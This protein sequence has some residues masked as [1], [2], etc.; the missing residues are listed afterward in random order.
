MCALTRRIIMIRKATLVAIGLATCSSIFTA[1]ASRVKNS[2]LTLDIATINSDYT[3]TKNSSNVST[4]LLVPFSGNSRQINFINAQISYFDKLYQTYG[5]GIGHRKAIDD[6]VYGI[7]GVYDYQISLNDNVFKRANVGLELLTKE[8]SIRTNFYFYL[9]SNKKQLS[10]SRSTS[11][12]I[13]TEYEQV[14]SGTDV[15]LSRSLG[16]KG[17][18]GYLGYFNY[19]NTI[20]GGKLGANYQVSNTVALFFGT[21]HDSQRGM[22]AFLGIKVAL[23]SGSS[24]NNTIL[25]RLYAPVKRDMSV[26]A[27]TKIVSRTVAQNANTEDGVTTSVE[28][29]NNVA[30]EPSS[31]V[32]VPTEG[33]EEENISMIDLIITAPG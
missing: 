19:G 1:Q 18:Q 25:D 10:Q 27:V 14:Y 28:D 3:N 4:N 13:I 15:E 11:D 7:F 22:M 32:P 12:N 5:L 24:R 6:T 26:F 33:S 21:Q 2:Q 8:W 23:G 30:E 20:T 17:L 9:D 31:G 29:E 16:L